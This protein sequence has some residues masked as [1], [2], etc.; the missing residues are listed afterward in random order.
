[1]ALLA[2]GLSRARRRGPR[3]GI[4]GPPAAL[5]LLL[6]FGI[7][8]AGA[9]VPASE[10]EAGV[11][12]AYLVNF[13]RYVEWPSSVVPDSEAPLMLCVAGLGTFRGILDR[14]LAERRQRGRVLQTRSVD[15][16]SA[17][18]RCNLLYLPPDTPDEAE[19]LKAIRGRPVLSVG[20]GAQFVDRDGMIG[21][22][23]VNETVRFGINLTAARA[24][25][26]RISSRVLSLATRVQD[27][28]GER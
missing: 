1:M 4:V 14:V 11:K 8:T 28:P 5:F 27:E 3:C 9:Q 15:S 25:G 26:L 23:I 7:G 24:A 20:E 2:A 17:A 13:T 12:A 21:F 10:L 16:P 18:D 19:W 22:V 6:G